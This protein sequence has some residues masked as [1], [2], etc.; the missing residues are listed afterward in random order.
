MGN[1]DHELH[2]E[3]DMLSDDEVRGKYPSMFPEVNGPS[4]DMNNSGND[5]ISSAKNDDLLE[6]RNMEYAS[7]NKFIQ[8][9]RKEE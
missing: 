5:S 7:I 6:S 3:E 4:Y 2:H 8:N 1:D 9:K